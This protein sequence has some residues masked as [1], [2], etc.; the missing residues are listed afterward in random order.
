MSA[1][2]AR[3]RYLTNFEYHRLPNLFTDVLVIG[4]GV[5]GLRAALAAAAHADVL[6][7]TKDTAAQSSTWYAQG[8]VAA[9]IGPD[10]SPADHAAD[11]LAVGCGLSHPAVVADVVAQAPRLIAELLDWGARFDRGADA[12]VLRGREGG[13]GHSR[14][15]HAN[16]DATGRELSRALIERVQQHP[17]I[18]L[19]EHCFTIDILTHDGSAVGAVTF[20]PKYGHQLLW[21][22]T[23][24][25]ATGGAG[26][27]YRETTN[28]AVA[29]G[30]GLAMALRAGAV[31]RDMEMVQFHPTT[32]YVAGAARALISEAVRGEGA[33][34]C[35][36]DG[37]RFMDAY[38]PR[39]EL[40]SRDVVSRA[41]H[42]EMR[43][44][45]VPCVYLDVRHFPPGRFADRFPN[46]TRLCRDVGLEPE[47][48]LIPVRP[49]AHYLVGGVVADRHARTSV[50]GLLACGE[51]AAS[52]LHGANRLASNS[53]LEGLV[54]GDRAGQLAAE[55]AAAQQRRE[56]P[57]TLAHLAP[58]S[59][60]TELDLEDVA[61]SLRSVMS[62]NVAVERSP[63]RLRETLEIIEFW[64][65]Y[66]LDKV[67]DAPPAWEIQNL[68]TVA[69]CI[70][71]AAA[72]RHES[73][74]V[75][76]RT[77]VP[78]PQPDWRCHVDLQRADHGFQI[79]TSPIP[80][81]EATA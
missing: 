58:R 41:I 69:Y 5:A 17:R 80:D 72:T 1:L 62:R 47:R 78:Q 8:G 79:G 66:T 27:V 61:H 19:F 51:V 50:P 7:I 15:V 16:G 2:I 24:V 55:R 21:A 68:L 30:D 49:S 52:G 13:H 25:L 32:L 73:R 76:F 23:T 35:H 37:A 57:H 18:R 33:F 6:V 56:H 39:G 46:L 10:D 81:P 67:F 26:R 34:L 38:D 64:A 54:F 71:A 75:H 59:Q 63:D 4:T 11:T 31:L 44:F 20:H 45:A 74:G 70:T 14:I 3:R 29:T 40:A 12:E 77:D 53:L 48:D 43:R 36:R 42:A 22:T 9:A 60:R 28:P 65:R